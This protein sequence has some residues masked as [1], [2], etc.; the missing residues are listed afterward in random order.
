MSLWIASNISEGDLTIEIYDP[1][2]DKKGDFSIGCVLNK[3]KQGNST[4]EDKSREI[5]QGRINKSIN[6]PLK[7]TWIIKIFPK[8][9]TGQIQIAFSQNTPGTIKN[10]N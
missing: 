2:G 5:V 6:N 4:D 8:N 10:E 7:G 3:I 9:A 1:S